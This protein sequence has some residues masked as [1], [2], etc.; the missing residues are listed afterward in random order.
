M[1]ETLARRLGLGARE[2]VA[3]TGAGGKSTF[4]LALAAELAGTGKRVLVTTTTKM[5][6]DQL[7]SVPEVCRHQDLP[8]VTKA[9]RSNPF[10]ALITGG[11]SGIGRAVAILE[12]RLSNNQRELEGILEV[13]GRAG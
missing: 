5:G 12:K 8:A 2:L 11:D 3:F 13:A 1:T 9:V 6:R 4:M 10:V 7:T